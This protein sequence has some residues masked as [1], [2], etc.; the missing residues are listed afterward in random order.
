MFH[1]QISNQ[2]Y[3]LLYFKGK[4][5]MPRGKSLLIIFYPVRQAITFSSHLANTCRKE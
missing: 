1:L 3:W 5:I 4:K 2:I